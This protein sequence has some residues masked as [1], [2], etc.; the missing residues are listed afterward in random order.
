VKAYKNLS[1]QSGVTHYILGKDYIAIKFKGKAQVYVY[2]E[3]NCGKKHIAHMK[4]L[5]TSGKGLSTYISLHPQVRDNYV[6]K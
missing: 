4:K 3:N 1:G 2:T 5:A 6:V